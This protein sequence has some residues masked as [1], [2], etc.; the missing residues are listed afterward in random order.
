[1]QTYVVMDA[2]ETLVRSWA[3]LVE[4]SGREPQPDEKESRARIVATASRE[5]GHMVNAT[6]DVRVLAQRLDAQ[7]AER[8]RRQ[9]A[10]SQTSRDIQ[11][12]SMPASSKVT[13]AASPRSDGSARASGPIG[14]ASCV[15]ASELLRGSTALS[16][17][18]SI[19]MAHHKAN[20]GT[21]PP[22]SIE[23]VVERSAARH[24]GVSFSVARSVSGRPSG[25][26]MSI[27]FVC[28]FSIRCA[29]RSESKVAGTGAG[30][31][32]VE[33]VVVSK[34]KDKVE[35]GVGLG[36]GTIKQSSELVFRQVAQQCML[37][38]AQASQALPP[39]DALSFLLDHLTSYKSL[40]TETCQECGRHL[41]M[42]QENKQFVLPVVRTLAAGRAFH[43]SCFETLL[44]P[45]EWR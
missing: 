41:I 19:R 16:A 35:A 2:A 9:V 34:W 37:V 23:Q 29:R 22:G 44:L 27:P 5:V 18:L 31:L 33:N 15:V 10:D 28:R 1:M 7:A 4:G 3:G 26:Q 14:A 17:S 8:A 40:F 30:G 42:S 25:I 21:Q 20:S 38:A 24:N 36:S 43:M 32:C 11:L 12:L 13:R 39:L 45:R 6:R